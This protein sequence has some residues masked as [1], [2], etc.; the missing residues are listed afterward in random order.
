MNQTSTIV[1][2]E[3]DW[4]NSFKNN[5]AYEVQNGWKRWDTNGR[6]YIAGEHGV[7]FAVF[8]ECADCT[9]DKDI[10]SAASALVV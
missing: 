3:T 8:V 2:D 5:H 1:P 9:E 10:G 4:I 6:Y 7:S